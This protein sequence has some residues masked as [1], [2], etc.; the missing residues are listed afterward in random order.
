MASRATAWDEQIEI[1]VLTRADRIEPVRY[2][3]FVALQVRGL[4]H[5]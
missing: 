2:E 5:V 3:S 1:F 4:H